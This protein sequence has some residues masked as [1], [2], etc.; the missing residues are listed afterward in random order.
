MLLLFRSSVLFLEEIYFYFRLCDLRLDKF[1]TKRKLSSSSEDLPG[2]R[3]RGKRQKDVKQ[4]KRE[5]K[6]G[7]MSSDSGSDSRCDEEG[8]ELKLENGKETVNLDKV[9]ND[10]A[11]A[12][13]LASSSDED[14]SMDDEAETVSNKKAQ[15]EEGVGKVKPTEVTAN[16]KRSEKTSK[17]RPALLNM[18]LSESDS[19]DEEKRFQNKKK[20]KA[21][22][23][24][25]DSEPEATPRSKRTARRRN[26]V[27]DS[28]SEEHSEDSEDED[29]SDSSDV[30]PA[31]KTKRRRRR[32]S[33]SSDDDSDEEDRP[34]KKRKRIKVGSDDSN[35]DE[36]TA[37]PSKS[38]RHD[39]RKIIK[40]KNLTVETKEAAAEERERRKRVE[41]RQALYN[42]T[43]EVEGK[44][45]KIRLHL[46]AQF[47]SLQCSVCIEYPIPQ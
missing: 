10:L 22:Q 39:I 9:K 18:K 16:G 12:A 47:S 28:D 14:N 25:Q 41:E 32:N 19:D 44:K 21:V 29:Q 43:F 17:N 35:S 46:S 45:G 6:L 7:E 13:V 42:K 27:I 5:K 24:D 2:D 40:D 8:Q 15:K 31:K 36:E 33:S 23:N 38:G 1:K 26:R 34:K 20:K 30:E 3:Q 11:K 37:S 4:S